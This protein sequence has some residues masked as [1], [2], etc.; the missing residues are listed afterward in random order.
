MKPGSLTRRVIFLS[1]A[2]TVVAI[3][4]LG[5]L[6]LAQFRA[7]AE[8][9]FTEL[10]KAQLFSL[11]GTI[12]INE[13]GALT[14][15]PN[16]GDS[17]FLVPGSGWFWRVSLLDDDG[18]SA[19]A[20]PSLAGGEIEGPPLSE[21]PYNSQ[22]ARTFKTPAIDGISI[23]VY[24][25]E[26]DLGDEQIA[27]FQVTGNQT[28]FDQDIR[29]FALRTASLLSLFGIGVVLINVIVILFGLRPL[30]RIRNALTDIRAGKAQKLEGEFPDEIAPMVSEMNVLIENNR[31]IVERAR[32]QV[33]NLAH[34]LKTPIAVLRNE[35]AAKTSVE[36][37]IV[38]AQ[39]GILQTQVEHYLNRARIAAQQGSLTFR[40]DVAGTGTR[41]ASVM[42]K[43]N[44]QLDIS[45]DFG[46]GSLV[47][48]GEKEDFEEVLGNLV[49]NACKWGQSKVRI[50]AKALTDGDKGQLIELRVE[51]DGPGIPES[52]RKDALKRGQRL[53]EKTPGTG[54]GLSIVNDTVVAY[55]GQT[56]LGKSDLG[57]LKVTVTLPMGASV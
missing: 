41:L 22:F 16:L 47:F 33:G 11:I 46:D 43:L 29:R 35:G 20:S 10:Q 14:G 45:A 1:S 8:R 23:R 49:E 42:T 53:D 28:E 9:N 13:N 15:S 12:S 55:G 4:L 3:A 51:D 25:A 56:E 31:S 17:N 36:A 21:I 26:I 54:L 30:D 27:L 44:P 39:A 18:R 34:S 37:R 52:D 19:V 2:W 7:G 50:T 48:A 5:W 32:T 40:T 6:L 57:G 24:E 38:T